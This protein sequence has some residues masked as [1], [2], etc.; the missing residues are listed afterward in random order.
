V[1]SSRLQDLQK[2]QEFS[3]QAMSIIKIYVEV[4]DSVGNPDSNYYVAMDAI[5]FE[6]LNTINALYGLTGYSVVKTLSGTPIVK[7]ANT[8]NLIEF[9]F[10]MDVV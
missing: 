9:R 4:L 3:W 10:A 6:N 1:L 5:R 7:E 8:S 2:S